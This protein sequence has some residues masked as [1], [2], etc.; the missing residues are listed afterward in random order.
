MKCIWIR[1]EKIS[2][3]IWTAERS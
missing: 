1:R 2:T 3:I